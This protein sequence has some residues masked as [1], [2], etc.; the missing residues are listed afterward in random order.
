[1]GRWFVAFQVEIQR[2]TDR[3]PTRPDVVAGVDLG[4]KCLA[5]IA[6]NRGAVRFVPN[7]AHYDAALKHLKR[8]SRRVARRQG[9]D[10]RTRQ[11]PSRR[12]AVANAERNRVHHRVAN[13]RA[14]GLHK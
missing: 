8:L 4:V 5:V 10:R 3:T 11:Q 14:D 13:L 12:W 1:R 2:A 9:P 6:D 7:P